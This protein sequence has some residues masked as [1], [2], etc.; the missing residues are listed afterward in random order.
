MF[1]VKWNHNCC[2]LAVWIHQWLQ[3]LEP[4]H[5][6]GNATVKHSRDTADP[7]PPRTWS[8]RL[9]QLL[10]SYLKAENNLSMFILSNL[11]KSETSIH[12]FALVV[13]TG[14][15]ACGWNGCSHLVEFEW[16]LQ[17]RE[18]S[19]LKDSAGNTTNTLTCWRRFINYR[20]QTDQQ[21]LFHP[22]RRIINAFTKHAHQRHRETRNLFEL[23]NK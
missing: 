12:S 18:L 1:Y 11:L 17:R 7:P 20:K 13:E 21:C 5:S 15:R 3:H 10:K 22:S 23:W 8:W 4:V 9:A 2:L 16:E 6:Q 19:P 14:S